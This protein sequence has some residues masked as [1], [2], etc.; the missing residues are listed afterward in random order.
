MSS[1]NEVLTGVIPAS[2]QLRFGRGRVFNILAAAHNVT[3]I[4]TQAGGGT[5]QAGVQ[6][7]TNIT[8]GAIFKGKKGEEWT[9][10][11]VIGTVGDAIQIYIGDDEMTFS[12]AVSVSGAVFTTPVQ[13]SPTDVADAVLAAGNFPAQI[14]ALV[15]KSVTVGNKSTSA[16]T[17]RVKQAGSSVLGDRG[18]ELTPGEYYNFQ[19][20]AALDVFVGPLGATVWQQN[21][22]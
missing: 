21:Y 20:S 7:F 5:N 16:D 19:T 4:A 11:D 3:V 2:G 18:V 22:I 17:I 10:L 9:Y 13:N 14:G 15:R 8:A 6:R 12:A 1:V